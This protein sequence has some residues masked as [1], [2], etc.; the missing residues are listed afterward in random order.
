MNKAPQNILL[1]RI[2]SPSDLRQL[3]QAQLPQLAQEIRD[4]LINTISATGGH[5]APGSGCS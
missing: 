3:K 4:Y 2:D 1:D 5:L